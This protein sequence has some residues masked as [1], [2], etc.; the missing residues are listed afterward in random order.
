MH[1]QKYEKE[2][3]VLENEQESQLVVKS[4]FQ[5]K[6]L[7]FR[8]YLGGEIWWGKFLFRGI[9]LTSGKSLLQYILKSSGHA[10]V[11]IV[12]SKITMTQN[13]VPYYTFPD[14]SFEVSL[15]LLYSTYTAT[16]LEYLCG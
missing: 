16:L 8:G 12:H 10:C 2:K 4:T 14:L 11:H 9:F 15:L 5:E 3:K 1:A 6:G 7:F 13:S